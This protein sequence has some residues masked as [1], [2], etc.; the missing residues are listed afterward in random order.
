MVKGRQSRVVRQD[1]EAVRVI[2]QSQAVCR[3]VEDGSEIESHCHKWT[4]GQSNFSL[5]EREIWSVNLS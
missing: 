4:E 5:T 3:D 1:V 2:G